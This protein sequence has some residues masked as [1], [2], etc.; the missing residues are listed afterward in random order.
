MT[1]LPLE[2][3]LLADPDLV[4]EGDS[5]YAAPSLAKENFVHPAFEALSR[6]TVAIPDKYS[7]CGGPF[8]L[9]AARILQQAARGQGTVSRQDGHAR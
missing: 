6:R 5:Q 4:V 7:I 1:R 9:E 2:Q 8:T 3:L